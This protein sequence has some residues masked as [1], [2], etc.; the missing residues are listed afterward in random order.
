MDKLGLD[1]I[2]W[3]AKSFE[4]Q[5]FSPEF[6]S[7]DQVRLKNAK[8]IENQAIFEIVHPLQS[9][10]RSER[11]FFSL[12]TLNTSKSPNQLNFQN[13]SWL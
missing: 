4:I 7:L 12:T 10:C 13:I 2:Y 8:R 5:S 9:F 3:V 1:S 6:C 11:F